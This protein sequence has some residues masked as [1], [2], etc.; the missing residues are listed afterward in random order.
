MSVGNWVI[1]IFLDG[2]EYVKLSLTHQIV[3][4]WPGLKTDWY[5]HIPSPEFWYD[6]KI[7]YCPTL[8]TSYFNFIILVVFYLIKRT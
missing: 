7:I 4:V 3:L 8:V 6:S 1:L 5:T 2:P